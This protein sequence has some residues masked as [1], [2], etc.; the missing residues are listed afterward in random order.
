MLSSDWLSAHF[1][2]GHGLGNDYLV[3]EALGPTSSQGALGWARS[4]DSVRAVCSRG[5]GEG[6]DGIVVLLD[7]TPADGIFPLAMFNPD[8]SAFERSGNGLRVLGAYLLEEGLIALQPDGSSLPFHVRTGGDVIRMVRHGDVDR[9][10]HDLEVSMGR[11]DVD[12]PKGRSLEHPTLGELCY[13]PV[14]TGNP[15]A[16]LFRQAGAGDE[17]DA[18][19]SELDGPGLRERGPFVAGHPAIPGGTN[20]QWASVLSPQHVVAGI[21]ERGVGRTTA[22]GTSACAIAVAGVATGR[23]QP[24]QIEVRTV[25]GVLYVKVSPT[26]DVTLRGP[27]QSVARGIL[28]SGFIDGVSGSHSREEDEPPKQEDEVG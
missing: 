2:R 20:V 12:A 26:L 9:G 28:T 18:V 11:A 23:L 7:R 16:V 10:V 27:V 13:I 19:L 24:G 6:S 4:A 25:G 21:W 17:P 22:S 5:R 15:H 1:F 8:G 14:R 3:F